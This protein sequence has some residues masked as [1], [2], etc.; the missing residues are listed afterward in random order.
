[1]IEFLGMGKNVTEVGIFRKTGNLKKQH[2]LME[3]MNKGKEIDFHAGEFN[4]HECASVSGGI[5]N[6]KKQFAH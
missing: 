6:I 2:K 4:I 1:M 5:K 3:M